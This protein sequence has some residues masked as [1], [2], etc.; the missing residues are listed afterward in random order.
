MHMHVALATWIQLKMKGFSG[1]LNLSLG[2][3][4]EELDV[5]TK[6]VVRGRNQHRRDKCY[7]LLARV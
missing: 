1:S 4:W 3:V 5:F 7:Q 2:A 6:F